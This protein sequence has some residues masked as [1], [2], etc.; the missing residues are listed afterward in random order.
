MPKNPV[1]E[2]LTKIEITIFGLL[3]AAVSTTCISSFLSPESV[4]KYI[5]ISK[6]NSIL[7]IFLAALFTILTFACFIFISKDMQQSEE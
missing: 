5:I 4:S 1:K 3:A 2:I 6:E 7:R